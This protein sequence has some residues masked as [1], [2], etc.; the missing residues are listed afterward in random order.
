M[1]VAV[2]R[3]EGLTS[4]VNV[5]HGQ[6]RMIDAG[7]IGLRANIFIAFAVLMPLNS[8]TLSAEGNRYEA[9]AT[10]ILLASKYAGGSGSFAFECKEKNWRRP[11][12]YENGRKR[13][14]VELDFRQRRSFCNSFSKNFLD[15]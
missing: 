14:L 10:L 11:N 1:S 6:R 12:L 5:G 4:S 3:G 2:R 13:N 7:A 9:A 8:F 15:S